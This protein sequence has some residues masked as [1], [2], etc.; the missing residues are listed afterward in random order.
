MKKELV[1][2]AFQAGMVLELYHSTQSIGSGSNKFAGHFCGANNDIYVPS[3]FPDEYI[4]IADNERTDQTQKSDLFDDMDS[5]SVDEA[6]KAFLV[7]KR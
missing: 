4:S 5:N 1:R 3:S 2:R 7:Q 6:P